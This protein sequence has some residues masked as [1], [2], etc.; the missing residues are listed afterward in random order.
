MLARLY[1]PR[2]SRGIL[3]GRFCWSLSL[4]RGYGIPEVFSLVSVWPHKNQQHGALSPLCNLHCNLH[5]LRNEGHG[6]RLLCVL[7]VCSLHLMFT[8]E[9]RMQARTDDLAGFS[10]FLCVHRIFTKIIQWVAVI[11]YTPVVGGSTPVR[12]QR[13]LTSHVYQYFTDSNCW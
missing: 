5:R 10:L 2:V 4:W 13:L 1:S 9:L 8:L 3:I 7:P 6:E 11:S 12:V